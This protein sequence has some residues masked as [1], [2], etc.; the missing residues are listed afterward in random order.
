MA[1]FEDP[2]DIDDEGNERKYYHS[3][4]KGVT[5]WVKPPEFD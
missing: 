2:Y 1:N 4:I 3:A 5:T